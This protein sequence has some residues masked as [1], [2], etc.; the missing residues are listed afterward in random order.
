VPAAPTSHT[1]PGTRT[2]RAATVGVGV[3]VLVPALGLAAFALDPPP[4]PFGGPAPSLLDLLAAPGM[5]SLVLGTLALGLGVALG[6]V[7]VGGLLAYAAERLDFPGRRWLSVLTVLPLALPSYIIASTT[8]RALSR[9]GPIGD[10]LGLQRFGGVLAAVVVLTVATAPYVQLVVRAALSRAGGATE[11]AARTLGAS[12]W[13]AFQHGTLPALRPALAYGGLVALLYAT[14]DFGAVAVL[15]APVLTWR[16][17]EAVTHQ[18]LARATLFAL[19][20]LAVV[21][22]LYIGTRVVRGDSAGPGVANPRAAARRRPGWLLGGAVA[23]AAV[24]QIGLGLIIPVASQLS[25]VL[26]GL[27]RGLAFA[28]LVE[29]VVHSTLAAAVAAVVTAAL[30]LGPA[31]GAGQQRGPWH[32]ASEQVAYLPSAVPGVLVAFGLLL[33]GLALTRGLG[34]A[35]WYA[36]LLGSGVLLVTGWSLRFVAEA[37]GPLR[38]SA[39]QV[40]PRLWQAARVLGGQR[41]RYLSSVVAPALAPGAGAAALVA[42]VAVLKELPVTLVL[43]SATGLRPLPYRIWDR[44]SEALWHDAGLAGLVLVAVALGAVWST[45]KEPSA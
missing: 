20:L 42:F 37:F 38:A 15:D 4:D 33:A 2:A 39:L 19:L 25:W 44:Y 18:D 9:G 43:G 14:S 11:E 22:P 40:D 21:G 12:P 26:D 5:G 6:A 3:L 34:H 13:R 41:G 29:P 24:L 7:L 35:E 17:F 23:L 10:L 30:A 32:T 45:L 1:P 27:H 28:P 36:P 16:L 31:W 8:S